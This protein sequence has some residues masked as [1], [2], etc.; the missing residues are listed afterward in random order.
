MGLARS[1]ANADAV[2]SRRTRYR[3]PVGRVRLS[4]RPRHDR[5]ARQIGKLGGM[6][7]PAFGRGDGDVMAAGARHLAGLAQGGVGG[8]SAV[9]QIAMLASRF[10]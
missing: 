6:I 10:D 5:G 9:N 8:L 1:L 2:L 3:R 7:F 4:V